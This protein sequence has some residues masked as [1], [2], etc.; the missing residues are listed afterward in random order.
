MIAPADSASAKREMPTDHVNAYVRDCGL[1][2]AR[3]DTEYVH[4]VSAQP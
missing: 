4:D 3:K 2:E 1:Q